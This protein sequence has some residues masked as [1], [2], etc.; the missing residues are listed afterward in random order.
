MNGHPRDPQDSGELA[1]R[2]AKGLVERMRALELSFEAMRANIEG[3]VPPGRR[4]ASKARLAVIGSLVPVFVAIVS[5]IANVQ[6]ERIK[7]QNKLQLEEL[8][9]Q[10]VDDSDR[11]LEG[12]IQKSSDESAKKAVRER[13]DEIDR[14]TA[15]HNP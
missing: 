6:I 7:A 2:I 4:R 3:S 13:D 8:V 5:W 14:V 15:R 12:F 10:K 11:K 1:L 9:R